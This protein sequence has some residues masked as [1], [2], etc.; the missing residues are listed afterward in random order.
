MKKTQMLNV[1][2][3]IQPIK[4]T[5]KQSIKK[6]I[7]QPNNLFLPHHHMREL[8]A[9]LLDH[10]GCDFVKKGNSA[11]KRKNLEEKKRKIY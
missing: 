9:Y 7:K 2:E 8:A 1:P 6:Q 10:G 11:K 4:N 3:K 5:L